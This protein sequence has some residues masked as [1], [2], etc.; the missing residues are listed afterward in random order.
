MTSKYSAGDDDSDEDRVVYLDYDQ[1]A[2]GDSVSD[3][4]SHS[5]HRGG[6]R[7]KRPVKFKP[8]FQQKRYKGDVS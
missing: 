5:T 2:E 7:E 4:A 1:T 8:L 3:S 6:P